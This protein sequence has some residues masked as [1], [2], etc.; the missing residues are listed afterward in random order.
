MIHRGLTVARVDETEDGR[1]RR[2]RVLRGY[3]YTQ[4]GRRILEAQIP[5]VEFKK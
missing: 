5:A 3:S 2:G 4:D 1:T